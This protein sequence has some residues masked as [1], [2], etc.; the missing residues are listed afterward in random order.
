V[1]ENNIYN[2]G[3]SGSYSHISDYYQDIDTSNTINGKPIYY[4]I[5]K[6]NLVFNETMS[7]GYLGLVSC[8][9]IVIKNLALTNNC[10][11]IL[12]A[13]TSYTTITNS[14]I[15][16]NNQS[17]IFLYE[18]SNN[19]IANCK[20]YN[21][22]YGIHLYYYSSNNQITNCTVYNNSYDGI[23]L[24]SYY[25][26][27][28]YNQITNCE[29]YNNSGDG[30]GLTFSS[31]NT[32]TNCTV[33]NNYLGMRLQGAS[34][35][36]IASNQIY[37]NSRDGIYLGYSSS[38]NQ[39]T[40][41]A[42][43]NNSHDG[44]CLCS[45][46][47]N[48]IH[49]NNIYNNMNY[50]IYNSVSELKYQVN[51]TYNWL[52]SVD[53][54]GGVGPGSGDAISSNV[55]YEPWLKGWDENILGNVALKPIL[56]VNISNIYNYVRVNQMIEFNGS[57]SQSDY[58]TIVQYFFD[59]SDGNNIGWIDSQIVNYSYTVP[60]QYN[61]TLKVK[62]DLGWISNW[63]TPIQITVFANIPPFAILQQVSSNY[64]YANI[65]ISGY[66][67]FDFDGNV[68]QYFFDFGDN[69]TGWVSIPN[70]TRQ[71]SDSGY[72]IVRLKV[73]D[74]EG[75]ESNWT[76]NITF[77]VYNRPPNAVISA[78][79]V[80]VEIGIPI[81]FSGLNSYDLDG[82]V[83]QYYF[84]FGDDENTGWIT[85]Y[86]KS[87]L[88]MTSGVY[89]VTLKV[90]DDDG[91][92]N[93]DYIMVIVGQP[94][95]PDNQLPVVDAGSNVTV[96]TDEPVLF[97]GTANDTDGYIIYYQ[98]DFNGD[99]G[100]DW[101]STDTGVTVHGYAVNGTYYA[102]LRVYDN[103]GG[104]STDTKKIIVK[105]GHA[106]TITSSGGIV[107]YNNTIIIVPEG[108]AT[109]N[110]T[111][112]ITKISTENPSGYI[113]I[114]DVCRIETD[115]T[116]F[117]QPMTL[118]LSYN[119]SNLPANVSEDDLAIY[120]KVGDSWLKLDSTVD[121][122]NNTVSTQVTNFSDYTILYK[123][124]SIPPVVGCIGCRLSEI[125]WLYIIIPV[126]IIIALIGAGVGIKKK[127]AGKT[128]KNTMKIRCPSCK[129][130][131]EVQQQE[132]PFKVKCPKCGK[133][134]T[135]K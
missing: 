22:P 118:I 35:N 6:N 75:L 85:D 64:T 51:A 89:D 69:T 17:G 21:N 15:Y 124:V 40:N 111:F 49:Y 54:P 61:I 59:F 74:N 96:Y 37:N 8:S 107:E 103:Q 32:I 71:Y 95:T 117:N 113:I 30:I 52:G 120:K 66:S 56:V 100:Y 58:G 45:A 24:Y 79:P 43:Y 119:E 41:S 19:Q 48:E 9:N 106:E 101:N 50:G 92:V 81:T 1:L 13:N 129:T 116:G 135:I 4:I 132:R 14:Y 10:Q 78:N 29:V 108:T 67:S 62:N 102:E 114:G 105:E 42:V 39:I 131:F 98:W 23:Q 27:C 87:H 33:Y 97:N 86:S 110:V 12:L 90:K 94:S 88:Y 18:S 2:F 38:N 115:V 104:F 77:Y 112:T 26:G 46:S 123:Q 28:N 122:T 91:A 128:K 34:N 72:H 25:G 109:Q 11:G 65:S 68:T 55:L 130:M 57:S 84:D 126:I 127:T 60:G 80:V 73:K 121:K 82:N 134:G 31:N 16:N 70:I 83:T 133:E 36:N 125:P 3:L 63:S 47:N 5:E 53:G 76:D 99:G 93:A 44:I 7:V 20:I